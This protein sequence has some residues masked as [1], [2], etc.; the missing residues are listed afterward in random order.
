[1]AKHASILLQSYLLESLLNSRL[2]ILHIERYDAIL[3]ANQWHTQKKMCVTLHLATSSHV[4]T[5]LLATVFSA[6]L[7]KHW[8]MGYGTIAVHRL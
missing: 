2:K 7:L 1:M 3:K 8:N 6:W 4:S 5:P